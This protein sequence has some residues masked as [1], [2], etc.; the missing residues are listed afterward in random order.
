LFPLQQWR[1]AHCGFSCCRLS[2]D[3][4]SLV[5]ASSPHSRRQSVAA[6]GPRRTRTGH[7][8]GTGGSAARRKHA[9]SRFSRFQTV[10]LRGPVGRP[11]GPV[12]RAQ[13]LSG[14]SGVTDDSKLVMSVFPVDPPTASSVGSACH[15]FAQPTRSA[16]GSLHAR[17]HA[18]LA[19]APIT[20]DFSLIRVGTVV[21]A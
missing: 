12:L 2:A 13:L 18:W 17:T 4:W 8:R 1:S 6:R 5:R 20:P 7:V 10:P 3:R 9:L 11:A 19:R 16:H 15:I 21:Q 14:L